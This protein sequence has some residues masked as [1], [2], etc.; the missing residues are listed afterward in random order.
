[1][2]GCSAD[3]LPGRPATVGEH[4]AGDG[5]GRPLRGGKLKGTA[6]ILDR[7]LDPTLSRRGWI[8]LDSGPVALIPRR[9]S[10]T[11]GRRRPNSEPHSAHAC[12]AVPRPLAG[13]RHGA[14]AAGTA[15]SCRP[16]RPAG[17]RGLAGSGAPRVSAAAA[18]PWPAAGPGGHALRQGAHTLPR[19]PGADGGVRPLRRARSPPVT[20]TGPAPGLREH[21]IGTAPGHRDVRSRMTSGHLRLVRSTGSR[22]PRE[23]FARICRRSSSP[24]ADSVPGSACWGGARPRPW[25]SGPSPPRAGRPSQPP[26]GRCRSYQPALDWVQA[27]W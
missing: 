12:L 23:T 25:P 7:A 6:A 26:D 16:E 3:P 24:L 2:G 14:P 15:L 13:V 5:S 19:P 21:R 18:R 4:L 10:A 27:A 20:G 8:N 11:A 17:T 1:M 22:A 9:R